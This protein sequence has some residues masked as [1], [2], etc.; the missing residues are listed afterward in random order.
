MSPLVAYAL[1][2]GP[3]GLSNSLQSI[4]NALNAG[5]K[6][7]ETLT[8]LF[9]V[10]LLIGVIAV[11]ARYLNPEN[12]SKAQRR[13]DIV[14]QAADV[15]GLNEQERADIR[16]VAK[17][18]ALSSPASILLSPANLAAAT[19]RA[20]RRTPDPELR[21][22]LERLSLKL[23]GVRLPEVRAARAEEP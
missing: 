14:R 6:T 3:L 17:G 23:F 4:R 18:A 22:R 1:V 10:V 9:G 2:A 20:L 15:L 16:R 13:L 19:E 11:C 12:R 5:P 21:R 8:V 7:D